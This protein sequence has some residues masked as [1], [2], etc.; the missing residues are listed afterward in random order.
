M[1]GQEGHIRP[2]CPELKKP[3]NE[4]SRKTQVKINLINEYKIDSEKEEL[5]S[6]LDF[7]SENSS[8]YSIDDS[9]TE[10]EEICMIIEKEKNQPKKTPLNLDY[11]V[12]PLESK[13]KPYN[14]W[15]DL[16]II[17][18][19]KISEKEED[20]SNSKEIKE[21]ISLVKEIKEPINPKKT[22]VQ[23]IEQVNMENKV[24]S[25]IFPTIIK[26]K[27]IELKVDAMLFE[28]LVP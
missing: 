2:E 24:K 19:E 5:I 4:R 18:K 22:T 21:P 16:Q 26:L 1:C 17:I 25:I 6:E 8:V 3:L 15:K 12:Q 20:S 10:K 27:T 28:N 13:V 9:E 7:E 23:T 14:M 11:L